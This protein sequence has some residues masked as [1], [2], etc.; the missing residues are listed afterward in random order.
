MVI[1]WWLLF[2]EIHLISD[3]NL[4]N[5]EYPVHL[6]KSTMSCYSVNVDTLSIFDT[7]MAHLW[8]FAIWTR[9][10]FLFLCAHNFRA[11][12]KNV[13]DH[14][15]YKG[16]A[17]VSVLCDKIYR[18]FIQVRDWRLV[19]FSPSHDSTTDLHARVPAMVTI[20][21]RALTLKSDKSLPMTHSRRFI[22]NQSLTRVSITLRLNW[23]Q[24]FPLVS[25]ISM[26]T[27]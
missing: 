27:Q 15:W 20:S 14:C 5:F 12:N 16:W 18:V 13:C 23:I 10:T 26:R 7:V 3:L 6:N 17:A 21:L 25:H 1:C 22:S 19:F 9:N 8:F 24:T 11:R 4:V 2:N